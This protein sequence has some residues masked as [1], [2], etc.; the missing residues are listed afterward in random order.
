VPEP[1]LPARNQVG[2]RAGGDQF[3]RVAKTPSAAQ[4]SARRGR[5]STIQAS[6][7]CISPTRAKKAP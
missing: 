2:K 3:G 5:A 6:P 7:N 4:S 1:E